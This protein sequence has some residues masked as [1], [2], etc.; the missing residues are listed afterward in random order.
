MW[1]AI[2]SRIAKWVVR[3]YFKKEF[4]IMQSVEALQA[5][6]AATQAQT[7]ARAGIC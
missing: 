4:V 3:R 5:Q 7:P 1:R 2:K 6:I